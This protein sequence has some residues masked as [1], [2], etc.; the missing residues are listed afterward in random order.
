M[1][2]GSGED[3]WAD[4]AAAAEAESRGWNRNQHS[5]RRPA[6]PADELEKNG[7]GMAHSSW[8]GLLSLWIMGWLFQFV[9]GLFC[10]CLFSS[11]V[12]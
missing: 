8:M 2:A 12:Y 6:G 7:Q 3:A 11:G 9:C 10:V 4:R 5:S 1:S